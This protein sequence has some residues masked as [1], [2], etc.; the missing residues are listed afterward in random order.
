MKGLVVIIC[1]VSLVVHAEYFW[2]NIYK[3]ILEK[4]DILLKAYKKVNLKKES[5]CEKEIDNLL[6]FKKTTSFCTHL[7]AIGF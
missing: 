6:L 1:S 3:N 5:Q 2:S 4:T 7:L